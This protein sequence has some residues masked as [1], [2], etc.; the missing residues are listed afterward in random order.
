MTKPRLVKVRALLYILQNIKKRGYA[1]FDTAP[2]TDYSAENV[3]K[4]ALYQTVA[5]KDITRL[6]LY[7]FCTKPLYCLYMGV[8]AFVQRL[9][10]FST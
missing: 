4:M 5:N 2:Y 10:T 6:Y 1:Y 3:K 9:C 7:V 8:V